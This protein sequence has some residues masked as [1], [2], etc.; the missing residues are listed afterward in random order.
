M[1][2]LTEN[3]ERAISDFD[4]IKTAI[5]DKGVEVPSITPTSEYG[6]K[7]GEVYENGKKSEYDAFWDAYQL[8]GSRTNYI[9]AFAGQGWTDETFKPKYPINPGSTPMYTFAGTFIENLNTDNI[10]FSAATSLTYTFAGNTSTSHLKH[11]GTLDLR[12]VNNMVY[13]FNNCYMLEEIDLIKFASPANNI[14]FN[15][16][17]KDCKGLKEIRFEGNIGS[18]GLDFR[19]S[20]LLSSESIESIIAALSDDTSDLAIT[21]PTAAKT[22][23]YTAH[24]SE[25]ADEDAAWNTLIATKPNWTISLN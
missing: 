3:I 8:G 11:I 20:N 16:T 24:E 19:W 23:Y 10:D 1:A 12:Y 18:N 13:T 14:A 7:V 5:E 4:S 6:E 25:Y 17:F 21:L 15:N 2:S 9:F 22:T